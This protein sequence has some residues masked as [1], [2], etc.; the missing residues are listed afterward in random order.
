MLSGRSESPQAWIKE[1]DKGGAS[2]CPAPLH[3]GVPGGKAEVLGA[4]GS[5]RRNSLGSGGQW[6]QRTP[7]LWPTSW[8]HAMWSVATSSL[9]VSFL[10]CVVRFS[11]DI[12]SAEQYLAHTK[13]LMHHPISPSIE[14]QPQCTDSMFLVQ[15]LPN[16]RRRDFAETTVPCTPPLCRTSLVSALGVSCRPV[17]WQHYL[18]GRTTRGTSW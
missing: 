10:L 17:P 5:G 15:I 13:G 3:G 12:L 6:G 14:V 2:R 4:G 1:G 8:R 16:R 7:A 11:N 18:S 9:S